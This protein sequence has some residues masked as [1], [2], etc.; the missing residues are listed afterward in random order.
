[1]HFNSS[2]F[3]RIEPRADAQISAFISVFHACNEL[4][5]LSLRYS[6]SFYLY[7][8]FDTIKFTQKYPG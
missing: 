4:H 2:V 8:Q 6:R 3:R 1:M 7:I 5:K